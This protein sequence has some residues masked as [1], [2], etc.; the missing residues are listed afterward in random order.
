MALQWSLFLTCIC[1]KVT[2]TEASSWTVNVPPSVKGLLGSCVV[3]PCSYKY[4]DIQKE[5]TGFVAIWYDYK[6][7]TIYHS[8]ASQTLEQFRTRTQLQG[9]ISKK[10]CTLMIDNL[11]QNDGGPFH[12]RT[13]IKGYD[14]FSYKNNKV[15]L[16][17]ISEPNPIDFSVQAEVKEGQTVSASCS[18]SHSCPTYPPAFHWSH[19]GV[20]RF[21]T[22]QLQE[23]Q[24]KATSTLTFRPNHTDHNK[25]LRCRVKF[26]GGT[27]QESS[28][29][30]KVKYAPVNVKVEYQSN[31]NE[32]ETMNLKCSSDA[33]PA[34]SY[35]WHSNTAALLYKGQNYTMSNVSRHS[36]EALYCTAINA[37]GRARSSPVQ[38]SVLY[39][40]D[41]KN[42]SKCSL[43]WDEVK[44]ECIVESNPPSMVYFVLADRVLQSSKIQENVSVT[45]GT[46][47]AH[48][49]SFLLVHCLANNTLGNANLTLALP[50]TGKMQNIF[51]AAGAGVIFLIILIATGVGVVKKCKGNSRD[52]PK[53]DSSATKA[54]RPV[55]LPHYAP[56]KRKMNRQDILC[57]DIYANDHIYGNTDC[58]ES[59]YNNV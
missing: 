26:H 34:S 10:N 55:E 27:R 56:T 39:A 29:T 14:Q 30:L 22:Q 32:G 51:I 57:P 11:Q 16:S 52:T 12:F 40:P 38:L 54:E 37:E 3:I 46:L 20:Q 24:W 7:R 9:D 6:D 36:V 1:F 45:T 5:V 48:F 2:P 43:E 31:V 8:D 4:S 47:Q 50:V 44:C 42:S 15:S 19:F 58:D 21:H 25:P 13:E 17:V 18:V 41:I 23:G 53:P 59:I 35:E 33:N 49:G 28:K